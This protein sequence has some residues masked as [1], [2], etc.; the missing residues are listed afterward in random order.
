[1]PSERIPRGLTLRGTALNTENTDE[2]AGQ[3]SL[4]SPSSHSMSGNSGG[5]KKLDTAHAEVKCYAEKQSREGR[6][7]L[8]RC[9]SKEMIF[10]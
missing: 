4:T 2:Q 10:D 9:L 7:R 6:K 8:V 5:G 1:M 3:K